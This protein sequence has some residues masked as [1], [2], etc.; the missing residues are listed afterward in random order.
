MALHRNINFALLGFHVFPNFMQFYIGLSQKANR[1][2][3][4]FNLFHISSTSRFPKTWTLLLKSWQLKFIWFYI[5]SVLFHKIQRYTNTVLLMFKVCLSKVSIL[6]HVDLLL[7]NN[8]EIS[9]Y[10]MGVTRQWPVNGNRGTLFP[11][12]SMLK[13]YRQDKSV[14][15][16][17]RLVSKWVS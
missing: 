3:L 9:N 12:Q 5:Y 4:H 11:V 1:K 7:G 17:S 14:E 6:W 16:V 13:C 8:H 2:M 10:A 15:W